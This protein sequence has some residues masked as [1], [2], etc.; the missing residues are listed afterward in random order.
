[1][2]SIS[3]LILLQVTNEKVAWDRTN[4]RAL[5]HPTTDLPARCQ[6]IISTLGHEGV[7]Y[8]GFS[9]F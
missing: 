9:S 5:G 2:R 3:P 1:M 8:Y 4:G 7:T 6:S